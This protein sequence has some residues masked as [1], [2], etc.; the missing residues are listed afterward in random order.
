MA[1]S[2]T[3]TNNFKTGYRVLIEWTATQ[4][5]ASNQSTITAKF[6]LEST[7]SGYTISSTAAKTLNIKIDGTTYT[8]SVTVGL[9]GNQKKLLATSSKT[10]THDAAG[11][12]SFDISGDVYLGISFSSGWYGTAYIANQ[13]FS[14]NQIARTSDASLNITTQALGSSITISTNRVAGSGFTHK[15]Y[16]D[17]YDGFWTL[18]ASDVTDSFVWTVPTDFAGKIPS[19]TSGNGRIAVDTYSGTSFIGSKILNFTATVPDTEAYRPTIGIPTC[20]ISGNGRD[21]TIGKY[22]QGVSKV[23]VSFTSSAKGGASVASNTINIKRQSDG[24]NSVTIS[25]LTGT[26]GFLSLSGTYLVTATVVDSRGRSKTS[27]QTFSVEPY[28]V[29]KINSYSA[30][31]DSVNKTIV[32]NS[33]SGT[34]T[35]MAGSNPL[36]VTIYRKLLTD[37]T[38]VSVNTSAGNTNGTFSNTY[39]SPSNTITLSYD[40]KIV[41]ADSFGNSVSSETTVSTSQVAFT[42]KKDIGVGVGKVWE[43]GAL[44]VGGLGFF[45]DNVTVGNGKDLILRSAVGQNDPGDIVFANGD[46]VEQARIYTSAAGLTYREGA[47]SPARNIWHDGIIGSGSNANGWYIRYPDGTQI[48]WGSYNLSVG[49]TTSWGGMFISAQFATTFP[50]GFTYSPSFY[51]NWSNSASDSNTMMTDIIYSGSARFRIARGATMASSSGTLR[52]MAIGRWKV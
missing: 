37:S 36:T 14:L 52:W 48:C 35:Y 28:T 25:G 3:L 20:S 50:I 10:V 16:S 44:D 9:S 46:G 31:R 19:L 15:I 12:R 4:N 47:S 41:V 22:V 23:Y 30:T 1:L 49:T 27:Q 40:F 32:N 29:P 8:H 43:Q 26:S 2:G 11:N 5:V 13:N 21:K 24:G 34:Y 45:S 17:F 7:G 18:I 51:A 39:A 33:A 38:Y 42:I 6:Y